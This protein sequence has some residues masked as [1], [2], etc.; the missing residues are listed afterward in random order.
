[1]G[2]T[3]VREV[4]ERILSSR[5]SKGRQCSE[6][7]GTPQCGIIIF[8]RRTNKQVHL[9]IVEEHSDPTWG[10]KTNNG[11]IGLRLEV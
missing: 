11:Y 9:V 6:T 3:D 5:S 7:W 8:L 4:K 1:M 10:G 2:K